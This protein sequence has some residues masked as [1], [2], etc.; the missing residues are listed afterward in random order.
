MP[1]SF[2]ESATG[3][4]AATTGLVEWIAD[5][6]WELSNSSTSD[7]V[8]LT[9]AAP[10]TDNSPGAA[11][12]RDL[13]AWERFAGDSKGGLRVRISRAAKHAANNIPGLRHFVL[14]TTSGGSASER[15]SA[16]PRMRFFR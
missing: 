14:V 7:A 6:R 15:M 1:E 12:E 16:S 9:N 2:L 13:R 5:S 10:I 4:A 8:P 11:G 3:S